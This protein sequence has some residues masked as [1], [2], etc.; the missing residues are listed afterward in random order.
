MSWHVPE[1]RPVLSADSGCDAC[2]HRSHRF[3]TFAEPVHTGHGLIHWKEEH[4]GVAEWQTRL[5]QNQVS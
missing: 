1:T 2:L 5:I 4:G 3:R